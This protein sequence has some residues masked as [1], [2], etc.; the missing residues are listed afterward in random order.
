MAETR[1][2]G[3]GVNGGGRG[4]PG[5]DD[6]AD[7]GDELGD[8]RWADDDVELGEVDAEA[9]AVLRRDE[10]RPLREA[11]LR[12]RAVGL[13]EVADEQLLDGELERLAAERDARQEAEDERRVRLDDELDRRD[14]EVDR[15]AADRRVVVQLRRNA[16]TC[17]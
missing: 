14:I 5:G 11:D 13:A 7:D 3:G 8:E 16:S 1:S 10:Q 2:G 12:E 4:G 9:G 17:R 6:G 15:D